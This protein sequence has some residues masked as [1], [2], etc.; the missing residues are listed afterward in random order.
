MT[1]N[2][3]R[4]YVC[5]LQNMYDRGIVITQKYVLEVN[6]VLSVPTGCDATWTTEGVFSS[7]ASKTSHQCDGDS[8]M[9]NTMEFCGDRPLQWCQCI[10]VRM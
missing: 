8:I 2:S 6:K 10:I 7:V 4:K 1:R 3:G 5:K 9:I